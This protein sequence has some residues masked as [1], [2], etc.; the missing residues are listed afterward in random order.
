MNSFSTIKICKLR[1]YLN[2]FKNDLKLFVLVSLLSFVS[3]ISC[4]STHFCRALKDNNLS[5]DY[6]L[7]VPN[8]TFHRKFV[9]IKNHFW[10]LEY[11]PT[12]S[13][14]KR[15][16][17]DTTD[18]PFVKGPVFLKE[19]WSKQTDWLAGDYQLAFSARYGSVGEEWSKTTL[20]LVN[21]WHYFE[22]I[23][24]LYNE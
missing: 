10:E 2:D 16:D 6:S 7:S 4:Q 19:V 9:I 21:V 22:S 23:L 20:A 24:C 12:N 3:S 11:N 15:Q 14:R 5:I 13:R 18:E 1:I 8:G 17:F